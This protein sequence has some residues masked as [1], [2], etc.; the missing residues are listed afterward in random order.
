MSALLF[1]PKISPDQA[2]FSI[3][4]TPKE[5]TKTQTLSRSRTGSTQTLSR[6]RVGSKTHHRSLPNDIHLL[7]TGDNSNGVKRH[8]SK[9]RLES[10]SKDGSTGSIQMRSHSLSL[11]EPERSADSFINNLYAF[12]VIHNSDTFSQKSS[13]LRNSLTKPL[14]G[15][16][17]VTPS[18]S[19]GTAGFVASK[20]FFFIFLT[21]IACQKSK[22]NQARRV[23]TFLP[24]SQLNPLEGV[25]RVRGHQKS[26][27]SDSGLSEMK[28][29]YA[30]DRIRMAHEFLINFIGS[31]EYDHFVKASV[32]IKSLNQWG[33]AN[34]ELIVS[35]IGAFEKKIE[36]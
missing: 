13:S 17:L 3:Q 30:Q 1:H 9:K 25:K 4:F 34:P 14:V 6:S 8:S 7:D 32:I 11:S 19:N 10:M 5:S 26:V 35:I 12:I 20:V 18:L 31:D 36:V 22:L 33:P 16:I 29:K 23:H 15:P 2:I 21:E 27:S 28:L 24:L